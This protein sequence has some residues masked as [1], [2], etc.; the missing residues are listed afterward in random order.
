M[1]TIKEVKIGKVVVAVVAASLIDTLELVEKLDSA[2]YKKLADEIG[3]PAVPFDKRLLK[4]VVLG[5]VQNAWYEATTGEVP[6]KCTLN[7]EGRIDRYKTA[8][9]E[10]KN[11]DGKDLVSRSIKEAKGDKVPRSATLYRL[12]EKT[13]EAWSA[14]RGQKYLI[15][16]AML[17]NAGGPDGTG[18]TVRTIADTVRDTPETKAPSDKNCA[19]HINAFGHEGVIEKVDSTGKVIA[20]EPAKPAPTK[21]VAKPAPAKPVA[22]P[23]PAKP[24][25]AKPVAPAKKK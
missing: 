13:K 9:D 2:T 18:C 15:V 21:P 23:A 24:A 5:A 7:Q 8:L 17:E 20:D 12:L 22:K 6:D 3:V 19:F 16:K 25:P 4:S 11:N 1:E 14:Y 10:I